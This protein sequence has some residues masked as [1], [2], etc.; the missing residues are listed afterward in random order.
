MLTTNPKIVYQNRHAKLYQAIKKQ[1]LDSMVLNAGSSLT[2]LTG[3]HFHLSERPAIVLFVPAAPL[4]IILPE[5]E[6][7][8]TASLPYPANVFVYREDPR[9]W[10][11]TFNEA[12]QAA[13]LD[14]H[15]MGVEPR[16]LR[17]LE[18][19]LLE[20]A[21]PHAIIQ[22]GEEAL[23]LLRIT[24]DETEIMA[25]RKAVAIAQ[26]AFQDLLPLIQ[27][28]K[29]EREL[30]SELTM[31]ILRHGSDSEMPFSPIVASGPN[32]ANPHSFPSDRSLVIG[33][34]LII[35]WGASYQGYVSDL[36][37]T[38]CIGALDDELARL[39]PLV[40]E[41][42]ASARA[43]AAPG[44]SAGQVDQA[45][46][47]VISQGGYGDYFIHRTGHGI[48]LEGH[49]APYIHAG[50]DLRLSPGMTFTIEPGIY[51]PGRGGVRI[52]DDIVITAGGSESLSDL[53]RD[54]ITIL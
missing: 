6:S 27:P 15:T 31:Q 9:T 7:G 11:A 22:S 49:E 47:G 14:R 5:L 36:T 46:R 35:D 26:A 13:G 37:R 42:N 50:N 10:Q 52:E 20:A 30:A 23:N 39:V 32:S 38:L 4:T 29:S 18:L 16:C 34:L 12:I 43:L 40:A 48:G 8:K 41:A 33:D 24:K 19:E 53:S 17:V 2:Y 25:M 51:L 28:G 54:L 1:G 45:A 44:I 21:A 3:L